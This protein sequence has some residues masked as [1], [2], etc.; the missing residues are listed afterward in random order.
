VFT[1]TDILISVEAV[2]LVCLSA[3]KETTKPFPGVK[4]AV[5][6]EGDTNQQT[7]GTF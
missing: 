6:T 4:A 7:P 2:L 5:E 3:Q 1:Q